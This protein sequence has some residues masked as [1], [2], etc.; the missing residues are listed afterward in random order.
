MFGD[1]SMLMTRERLEFLRR[2]TPVE[3]PWIVVPDAGHHI[4]VDQPLAL[5]ATLRTLLAAWQ[6]AVM[7]A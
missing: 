3:A 6:P 1:R 2:V 4:M 7:T 5:V